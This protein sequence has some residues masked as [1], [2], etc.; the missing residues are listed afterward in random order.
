MVN[1]FK[2]F[3]N[4]IEATGYTFTTK[5]YK[6]GN[7]DTQIDKIPL[8]EIASYKINY[9]ITYQG[10]TYTASRKVEVK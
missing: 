4:D 10:K 9:I 7:P 6:V 3:I 8:N 5:F 2:M 1:P